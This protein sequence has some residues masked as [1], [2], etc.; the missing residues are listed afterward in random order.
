MSET[1]QEFQVD[2]AAPW[3]GELP[4]GVR[5]LADQLIPLF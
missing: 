2:V 4:P 1:G 5:A 3:D